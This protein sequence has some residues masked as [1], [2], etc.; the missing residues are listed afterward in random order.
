M[1]KEELSIL[2]FNG[3]V[4]NQTFSNPDITG[5]NASTLCAQYSRNS[6]SQYDVIL[7]EPSGTNKI[8]SVA[9]YR[10]GAKNI[11][12]NVYSAVVGKT[13]QIT[14]EDKIMAQPTNFPTGRHSEY[15]AVTTVAN[16]WETLTFNL[17]SRPDIT[18]SDT[19]VSRMVLL[20]DP[21]SY[22]SDT[23]LFDDI[24][25]PDILNPCSSVN[26]D[27]TIAEDYECQRNVAFTFANG[28]HLQ[29]ETNP[30]QAGVN[31]SNIC[32]KFI[33]Y[34]PP[35][36]DGAF[37]GSFN[38][39]FFS[40]TFNKAQIDLYNPN[41]PCDFMIVMQ[42][43]SGNNVKDTTFT[44]PTLTNWATF[45]MDLSSISPTTEIKSFVLLL[46]PATTSVDTIY[47][48][49]FTFSNDN[50]MNIKKI[51]THSSVKLYP[52]PFREDLI[53]SNEKKLDEIAVFDLTGKRLMFI[54]Q[55][56]SNNIKLDLS[57]L[58]SGSYFVQIKDSQGSLLI[59]KV[60]K[61]TK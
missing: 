29:S 28:T 58:A 12:M 35:T 13:I 46:N 6:G 54:N 4:F 33:K 27:T 52:N 42:D 25:G 18:V 43:N 10:T 57:F 55:I 37:G 39:P 20:F 60:I 16:N 9:D 14:L 47:L 15:T 3:S 21:N 17:V 32:G 8:G 22:T 40:T 45:E 2:F 61:S 5:I 30:L 44:I 1:F 51:N 48:D 56:N 11:T 19:S 53:I 24:M 50:T 38:H 31:T 49:N 34:T 59:E 36:N 26:I 41:A 23:Y 7:I